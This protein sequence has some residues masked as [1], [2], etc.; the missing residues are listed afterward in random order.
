M[1]WYYE[2]YLQLADKIV[3]KL[4][5]FPIKTISSYKVNENTPAWCFIFFPMNNEKTKTSLMIF[6]NK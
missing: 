1:L 6:V 5:N 3:N 2:T 4:D